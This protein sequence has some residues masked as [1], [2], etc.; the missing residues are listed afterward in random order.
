MLARVSGSFRKTKPQVLV[1]GTWRQVRNV[2]ARVGNSW[3]PAWSY[4]WNSGSWGGC[5]ASCGGG[6]QYRAVRC[7]RSD[8][9]E[10][11]DS[12]CSTISGKPSTSQSCNSHPCYTYSWNYGNWS[13]CNASC[14]NGTRSRSVWCQRNDGYSTADYNCSGTKPTASESC[15]AG[16]CVTYTWFSGVFSG[17]NTAC[18]EGKNTRTVYCKGS[19][20][21]KYPDSYCPS[22]SKPS[23]S[24]SCTS[25]TR[26]SS[27]F[28]RGGGYARNKLKHVKATGNGGSKVCPNLGLPANP[29][30]WTIND[31]EK[32]IISCEGMSLYAHYMDWGKAESVC[33]YASTVCCKN[34]G[35]TYY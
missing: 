13:N 19:D 6:T 30:I 16:S 32:Q 22:I 35:Y 20:G 24:K 17:C 31:L 27:D 9:I 5:S 29:K 28:A 33:P 26:C 2:Y 11:A 25:C 14:G 8:G 18:G 21:T 3:R 4:Y 15:Y 7:M 12:F 23:T 10:M 1:Y 34:A